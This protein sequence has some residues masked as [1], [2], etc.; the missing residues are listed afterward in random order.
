MSASRQTAVPISLFA[1]RFAFVQKKKRSAPFISPL[2][3]P[4]L[5]GF[6]WQRKKK[7]GESGAKCEPAARFAPPPVS[8]DGAEKKENEQERTE[9]KKGPVRQSDGLGTSNGEISL[10]LCDLRT[11]GLANR[12]LLFSF[13]RR[14]L[15]VFWGED[16]VVDKAL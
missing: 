8:V 16:A 9:T 2:L 14:C 10:F 12:A 11:C 5:C 13:L 15:F 3:L 1:C 4:A 7:R 6:A